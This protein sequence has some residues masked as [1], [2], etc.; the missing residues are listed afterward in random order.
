MHNFEHHLEDGQLTRA[1][2]IEIS[3]FIKKSIPRET[4]LVESTLAGALKASVKRLQYKIEEENTET[5]LEI[6]PTNEEIPVQKEYDKDDLPK[7]G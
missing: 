6:I 3:E 5:K 2:L 4:D 1:N 7:A